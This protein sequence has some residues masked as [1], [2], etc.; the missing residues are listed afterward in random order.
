MVGEVAWG[1]IV[2]PLNFMLEKSL[3]I[4]YLLMRQII[5]N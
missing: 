3:E 2:N 5:Y 4:K 1:Q